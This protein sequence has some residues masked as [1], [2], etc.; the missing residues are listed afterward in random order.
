MYESQVK[1]DPQTGDL[2]IELPEELMEQLGW[3]PGDLLEWS[4]NHNTVYVRKI[5][6]P[7]VERTE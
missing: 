2:Y 7:A 5:D 1:E 6:A 4:G 3:Q